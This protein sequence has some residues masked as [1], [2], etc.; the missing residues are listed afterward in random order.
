MNVDGNTVRLLGVAQ[1]LVFV[2]SFLSEQLLKSAVG[3]GSISDKLVNI[4][5]NLSKMRLSNVFALANSVAI[6]VLGALFYVVLNDQNQSIALVA[7][8]LYLAEAIT[9]AV[10]KLGAFALMPLS[11]QFVQAGAPEPSYFQTLGE[12]L[13]DGLDRRGYDIHML[14]FCLGAV[15]WYYLLYTSALVPPGLSLW[16]LVAVSLMTIPMVLVLYDRRFLPLVVV[17]LLYAPYEPVLGL[18]LLV[19]GFN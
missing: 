19:R 2:A 3:A 5:K 17:A 7:L 11:Q 18:W 6:I 9:V 4:S 14:F 10:S 8:G 1:L 12:W 15:L 13:Y 16:G